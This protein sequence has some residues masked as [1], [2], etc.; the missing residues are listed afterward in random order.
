M[1]FKMCYH[2]TGFDAVLSD[3]Q[4]FSLWPMVGPSMRDRKPAQ[5]APSALFQT[6]RVIIGP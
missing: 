3:C 1:V 5:G 2:I 6:H 4:E